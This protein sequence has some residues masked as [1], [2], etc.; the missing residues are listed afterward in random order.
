MRTTPPKKTR[1]SG[2]TVLAFILIIAALMGASF[3]TGYRMGVDSQAFK[4]DVLLV[5]A[6]NMLPADYKPEGLVNLY[7]QRHSFR[8]ENT[9]IELTWDTYEAM[10]ALFA[11][12]EDDNMN[13]YII[14]SGYRPYERQAELYA[15]KGAEYAQPPGASEHQTGM[16]FDVTVMNSGS[17]FENTPHYAWLMR[18]AHKYGFIQ[19]YPPNKSHITGISYEPWHFR[20]VGVDAATRIYNTGLTLEEFLDK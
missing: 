3:Y 6:Q 17:G 2:K 1:R 12:A 5:N 13:G 15:E 20:Y 4:G 19:R 9:G 7:S 10:E 16:A 18:N 8:L 14:T 11:A